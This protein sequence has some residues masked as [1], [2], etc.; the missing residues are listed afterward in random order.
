MFD[1]P[2]LLFVYLNILVP[3]ENKKKKNEFTVYLIHF[4]SIRI[5]NRITL[6]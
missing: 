4:L 2:N 3:N 1:Y 5:T 6:T